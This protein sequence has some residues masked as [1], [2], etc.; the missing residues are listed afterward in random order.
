[1]NGRPAAHALTLAA[2]PILV[3]MLLHGRMAHADVSPRP[4]TASATGAR[5]GSAADRDAA[6]AFAEQG[7]EKLQANN[8]E[9]AID[10]F[11]K[12]E[13]LFHAPTHLLYVA[14]AR[15]KKGQLLEA[16]DTYRKIS[17]ESLPKDAPQP[18]RD[19]QAEAKRA[20]ESVTKR[21]PKLRVEV[22]GMDARAVTLSANG[23]VVGAASPKLMNPGPYVVRAIPQEG[24]PLERS[25][26]LADDGGEVLVRF[27]MSQPI[28]IAWP[29][30]SMGLGAASGGVAISFGVLAAEQAAAANKTCATAS[31]CSAEGRK[32]AGNAHTLRDAAIV[33][34][35]AGGALL[36]VGVTLLL[37]RPSPKTTVDPAFAEAARLPMPGGPSWGVRITPTSLSLVGTF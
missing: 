19:A 29:I 35:I 11:T 33:T 23:E 21:T 3:A 6:R 13:E 2:T 18:F 26:V 8:L 31:G 37:V 5:K 17:E 12:A 34:G 7:F 4:S 16:A 27:E 30:L 24:V 20:F 32:Q 36:A 22:V 1:M 10:L 25:V 15:E 28:S 9:E 14:K